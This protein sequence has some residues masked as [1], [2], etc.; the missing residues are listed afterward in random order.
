MIDAEEST[1]DQQ[2]NTPTG[3]VTAHKGDYIITDENSDKQVFTPTRFSEEF[4]VEFGK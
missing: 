2:V 4:F 1:K 3:A